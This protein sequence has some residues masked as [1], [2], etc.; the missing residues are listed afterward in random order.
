MPARRPHHRSIW[1]STDR[2]SRS[3]HM[4]R[5]TAAVRVLVR[6][7]RALLHR[8]PGLYAVSPALVL[9]ARNAC[10][11]V[12]PYIQHEVEEASE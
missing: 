3:F 11:A 4:A 8:S 7:V 9:E 6:L 12:D 2:Q 1:E 5:L 10:D